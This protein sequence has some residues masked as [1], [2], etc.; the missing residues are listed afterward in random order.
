MRKIIKSKISD[1]LISKYNIEDHKVDIKIDYLRA[2]LSTNVAMVYAKRL[3]LNPIVLADE[4]SNIISDLEGIKLVDVI[5]P[6][7]IN[8]SLESSQLTKFFNRVIEQGDNFGKGSNTDK[9]NVEFVS[10]NPTGLLHVGHA[11]NAAVGSTL[12]NILR[13]S[14][15][16]VDAEYYIND[17]GN[18]IDVLGRSAFIRYQQLLGKDVSLPEESYKGLEIQDFAQS[19]VDKVGNKYVD[20]NYEDVATEFKKE[21]KKYMLET[22]KKDLKRFNVSFDIWFSEQSLY[23][24]KEIE[25]TLDKLTK[26]GFTYEK[27]GAVWLKTTEFGD[28]KDRVLKKSDGTY[29]Y[30]M[31]D[32]AYHNDKLSRGYDH[33]INVWGADHSGYVKRMES[34]LEILGYKDKLDVLFMQLVR[35]I[36]DG[37]EW[38][39][40]KRAGTTFSVR[41]LIDS[42]DTSAARYFLT[43]R[44][45][46]SKLDFDINFA[47]KKSNDNPVFYIQYAYA[48]ANQILNHESN[49]DVKLTEVKNLDDPTEIVLAKNIIEFPDLIMDI[50]KNYKINLLNEYLL[51]LAKNFHLFYNNNRVINS[52]YQSE[53]LTLVKSIKQLL[54]ICLN[55][56]GVEAPERM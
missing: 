44:S 3:K 47:T 26:T 5:K 39:M 32:I 53:K 48:R 40:S 24:N 50:S 9:V 45:E 29:T 34:A 43:N 38:K 35:L 11:R 28:D 55:L 10:A 7:F 1:F 30:L 21:S 6:G 42:V 49:I 52:E 41:D 51:K 23:D 54:K 33:I 25:I 37:K 36:K 15:T 8:I 17:A 16:N 4:I 18:Q 19:F 20:N 12:I 31:P 56:I 46:N 13:W 22:I 2:D 14:G 27:D